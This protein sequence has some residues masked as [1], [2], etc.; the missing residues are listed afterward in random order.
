MSKTNTSKRKTKSRGLALH[1]AKQFLNSGCFDNAG[2]AALPAVG[3]AST[4]DR[5]YNDFSDFWNGFSGLSVQGVGC[6][7][8]EGKE[9]VYVYVTKGV[10]RKLDTISGDKDGVSIKVINIGKTI[11]RP[12]AALS[13]TNRGNVFLRNGRIACGSSC[14]PSGENFTGTVGAIIQRGNDLFA[15]S[16]NHVFG[17]CNHIPIGQPIMSPSNADTG[18]NVPAPRLIAR[19]SGIMELRSGDP[20]LVPTT[21]LD[22]AYAEIIPDAITSWQGDEETG[23]D[24]PNTS[25]LPV[26]GMPVKKV[27]RTTG[28][29]FGIVESEVPDFLYLPYRCKKFT[30][31]V[32]FQGIWLVRA[33]T[34]DHFALCGDSGSLVVSEDGKHAVGLLFAATPNGGYGY[35]IPIESILRE[36]G[37]TLVSG[38]K[39]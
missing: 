30:A 38:Y 34:S 3:P 28:L 16:N 32:W 14:H 17:A 12:E 21:S 11:I 4:S 9:K 19:H 33:S 36:L 1:L 35:I 10:K 6:D 29:T 24:T 31:T 26:P 25:I 22:A 18:P 7:E 13:A 15:L 37:M 27:G 20:E 8:T 39:I 2:G 5:F 23:Y